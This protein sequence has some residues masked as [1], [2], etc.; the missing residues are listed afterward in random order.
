MS[1][2]DIGISLVRGNI[3]VDIISDVKIVKDKTESYKS[4]K[5]DVS[6]HI[7]SLVMFASSISNWE[8]R[9][10]D[11]ETMTYMAYYPS[12]KLEKKYTNKLSSYF[13]KS[14]RNNHLLP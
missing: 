9:Y 7:Y 1:G 3:I 11:T 8:A 2:P 12:L 14:E 10:G 13:H 5:T 4:I 6:S